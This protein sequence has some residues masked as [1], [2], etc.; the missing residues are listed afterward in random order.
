MKA[1]V[2]RW[3]A[4]LAVRIPQLIAQGAHLRA[5]DV[6]E[7][8]VTEYG[9]EIQRESNLRTLSQLVSGITPENQHG[10]IATSVSVGRETTKW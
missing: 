6:V 3:G 7:I 2:S 8:V 9:L 4:S 5:G 10:E 1:R